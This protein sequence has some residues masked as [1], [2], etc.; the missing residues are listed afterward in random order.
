MLDRL[1]SAGINVSNRITVNSE[2]AAYEKLSVF[3]NHF[4]FSFYY[5]SNKL[6]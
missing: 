1:S 2:I 5:F 4:A 3:L 6:F